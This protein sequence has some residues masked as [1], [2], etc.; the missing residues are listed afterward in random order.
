[1]ENPNL[2]VRFMVHGAEAQVR[3][4]AR[5][6]VDGLGGLLVYDAETGEPER[7]CLADLDSLSIDRP[8]APACAANW[9]N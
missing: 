5:I 1:M 7:L 9:I 4:A 6:S 8:P 2:L 3:A